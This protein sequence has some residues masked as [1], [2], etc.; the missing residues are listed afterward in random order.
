MM[1]NNFSDES[2]KNNNRNCIKESRTNHIF[3]P[4]NNKLPGF[5]QFNPS[6]YNSSRNAETDNHFSLSFLSPQETQSSFSF[7]PNLSP[8]PDQKFSRSV[9]TSPKPLAQSFNY[10]NLG[11]PTSNFKNDLIFNVKNKLTFKTEIDEK[12]EVENIMEIE[13]KLFKKLKSMK[14]NKSR[15]TLEA[16]NII[17][18]NHLRRL[19]QKNNNQKTPNLKQ[20]RALQKPSSKTLSKSS[21]SQSLPPM[22]PPCRVCGEKASGFHYGA[23]TCEACKVCCISL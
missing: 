18:K 7:T 6:T 5:N 19:H 8:I 13:D 3:P 10:N 11:S 17:T 2:F 1:E 16:E 12:Y 21:S 9:P 4:Y 23:N 15:K 14:T 20:N 22:L